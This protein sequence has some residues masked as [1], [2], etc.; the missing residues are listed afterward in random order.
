MTP[1]QW[2]CVGHLVVELAR[3]DLTGDYLVTPILA[4]CC[5][6]DGSKSRGRTRVA[7]APDWALL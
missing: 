7:D 5:V 1:E 3:D 2:E 6:F 4:A